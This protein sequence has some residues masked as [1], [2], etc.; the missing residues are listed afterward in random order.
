MVHLLGQV[1]AQRLEVVRK[2]EELTLASQRSRHNQE[3]LLEARAQL[4]S[5]EARMLEAQ[6]KLERELQRR[7]NLEEKE[8]RLEDKLNQSGEQRGERTESGL[9]CNV[10]TNFHLCILNQ[11]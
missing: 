10:S 8:E 4:E 5:L 2:E 6:E 11:S 9:G 3:A 7:R 1:E